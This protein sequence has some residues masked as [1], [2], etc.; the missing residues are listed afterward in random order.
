M[1]W[2]PTPAVRALSALQTEIGN[3]I[4]APSDTTLA[5]T[6]VDY[7][8]DGLN[9]LSTRERWP[10][11]LTSENVTLV[12][13]TASYELATASAKKVRHVHLLNVSD[14]EVGCL[15]FKDP[16]TFL[17]DYPDRSQN[18][19]PECYTI[20]NLVADGKLDLSVPP[21][22]G[23]VATYPKLKV[24]ILKRMLHFA[25]ASTSDTL[26]TLGGGPPELES[27][28]VWHAKALA[29]MTH[30]P[31]KEPVARARAFEFWNALVGDSNRDADYDYMGY[32]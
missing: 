28:L 1:V 2:N 13:G 23:F 8:N 9:R 14:K 11:L 5:A 12:A 7:L 15:A 19:S 22:D 31:D 3:Y 4:L 18:G 29:A 16:K 10:W 27:Y 26:T 17:L 32:P 20:F 24:R 25:S 30:A 21:S 6:F